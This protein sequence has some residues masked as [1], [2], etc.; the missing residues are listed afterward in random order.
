[1][2]RHWMLTPLPGK[3]EEARAWL[4][5]VGAYFEK[6]WPEHKPRVYAVAVG[7]TRQFHITV[8]LD[9]FAT[10]DRALAVAHADEG[11]MQL[12]SKEDE[13]FSEIHNEILAEL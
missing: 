11:F 5:E 4:K 8:G 10:I 6:L 13:L 1:M 3:D 2:I 7:D 12:W 9:D